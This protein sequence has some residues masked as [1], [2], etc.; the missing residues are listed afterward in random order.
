MASIR[1]SE[2]MSVGVARLDRDHQILIGLIN[3]IDEAG[4][5]ET[6]RNRV[7]PEVLA[8]LIAYTVFHFEREEKVM[9][10]CGYPNMGTHH[11]EHRALTRE[12]QELQRRYRRGD[13]DL[14]RGEILTFLVGWLNHHIL[15]QDMDYRPYVEGSKVA[16]DAA[17]SHGEFDLGTLLR[18]RAPNEG[19]AV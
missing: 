12:V 8:I 2:A 3:R 13:P 14:D 4:E 16:D 15:L 11:E 17:E 6:T 10:A 18:F 5:D 19:E 7:L 1:W 9:R